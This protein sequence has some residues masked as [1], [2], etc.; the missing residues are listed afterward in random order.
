MQKQALL[1]IEVLDDFAKLFGATTSI[2]DGRLNYPTFA[3]IL[4]NAITS[5][6]ADFT[7]KHDYIYPTLSYDN[8]EF[9]QCLININTYINTGTQQSIAT[10]N[11]L[12]KTVE[13]ILE[14]IKQADINDTIRISL[15]PKSNWTERLRKKTAKTDSQEEFQTL[16]RAT[17]R[18]EA[19]AD[20]AQAPQNRRVRVA[21]GLALLFVLA[22]IEDLFNSD[23]DHDNSSCPFHHGN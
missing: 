16:L 15:I 12:S 22:N 19:R 17:R 6:V 11:N 8:F 3:H 14:T 18:T 4:E 7:R 9:M 23:D 21:E 1:A 2:S 10:K 13:R 20:E 5:S